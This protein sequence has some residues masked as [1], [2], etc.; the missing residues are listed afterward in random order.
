[1]FLVVS[2]ARTQAYRAKQACAAHVLAMAITGDCFA[3]NKTSLKTEL[4]EHRYEQAP[5]ELDFKDLFLYLNLLNNAKKCSV[6][7]KANVAWQH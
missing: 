2:K 1:M 7:C 4:G 3:I 6:L 5:L